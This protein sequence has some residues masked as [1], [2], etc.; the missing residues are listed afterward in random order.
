MCRK[1]RERM[2]VPR[3]CDRFGTKGIRAVAKKLDIDGLL[4]LKPIIAARVVFPSI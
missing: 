3:G 1:V 4:R 2:T